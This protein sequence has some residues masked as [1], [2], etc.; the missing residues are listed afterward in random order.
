MR[1]TWIAI[2][3]QL[4]ITSNRPPLSPQQAADILKA[5]GSQQN[6]ANRPNLPPGPT[7]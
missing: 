4:V 1:S 6:V 5:N 2:A 3:L 7:R